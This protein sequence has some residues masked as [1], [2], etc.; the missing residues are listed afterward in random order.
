M[1]E[2]VGDFL[3]RVVLQ[4]YNIVCYSM[5]KSIFSDRTLL[6]EIVLK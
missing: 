6:K 5:E 3:I 1:D 2:N 4:K